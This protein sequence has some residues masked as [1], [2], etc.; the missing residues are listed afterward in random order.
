MATR[1]E[2]AGD[3]A[4]PVPTSLLRG[5]ALYSGFSVLAY[6]VALGK[7][8]LATR[9][10]GTSP[11]MDAYTIAFAIPLL[12]ASIAINSCSAGLIPVLATV[13][14][15][16]PERRG[17]AL[18][19]SMAVFLLVATTVAAILMLFPE[20]FSRL[21]SPGFDAERRHLAASML[22]ILALTLPLQVIFGF[23]SADLLSRHKHIRAAIGPAISNAI[24]IFG[25]LTLRRFGIQGLAWATLAG[26]AMQAIGLC[27]PDMRSGWLRLPSLR[28][29]SYACMALAAQAPLL[30]NSIYS[31]CNG[32]VDQVAAGFLPA[33]AVS[34]IGYALALNGFVMVA[35][36]MA[37]GWAVLPRFSDL[38]STGNIEELK[39]AARRAI[40]GGVAVAAPVTAAIFVLGHGALRM[41]FQYGAFTNHSTSLVY[42]IWAGYTIGIIPLVPGMIAVRIVNSLRMNDV[43]LKLGVVS[44]FINA[45]LDFLLMRWF[46]AAGIAASTSMVYLF[47]A[48]VLSLVL[49]RRIGRIADGATWSIG[50]RAIVA[51]GGAAA[52]IVLAGRALPIRNEN[53]EWV[54]RA[55][56]LLAATCMFYAVFGVWKAF[57]ARIAGWFRLPNMAGVRNG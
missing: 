10:F 25:I 51:A 49:N 37:I 3:A 39:S 1:T 56:G 2:L 6:V 47:N 30:L 45:G 43:L 19:G 27:T 29:N 48:I 33:G 4:A 52:V 32:L 20:Q 35:V 53:L 24:I 31:T 17:D 15:E 18:R 44:L 7:T 57:P 16:D 42:S 34:G 21:V 8:V 28:N 14:R 9:Y 13:Q 46:G 22:R 36:P 26:C 11:E 40:A 50:M 23:A 12:L 54:T 38:L 5:S 41:V 55:A